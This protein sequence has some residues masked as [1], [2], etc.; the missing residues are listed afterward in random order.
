MD[1]TF[2]GQPIGKPRMTRR[3]KW[4]QRSCVVAYRAWCD[5]LRAAAEVHGKTT[6]TTPT[7]VIVQAY[8]GFPVSWCKKKRLQQ[9]QKP[10]TQKPD[11]D[12][13]LKAVLDALFQNDEM[14]FSQ[15]I[16]K[17]WQDEQGARIKIRVVNL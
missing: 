2:Y 6:L 12:N 7:I 10:H 15:S 17:T 16:E 5:G 14:V 3:D 8:F 9:F 4:K 13:I 11:G 1:F